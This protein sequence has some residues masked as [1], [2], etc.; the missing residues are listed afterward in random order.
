MGNPQC[1]NE[2]KGDAP[3]IPNSEFLSN[4]NYG[5]INNYGKGIIVKSGKE[6]EGSGCFTAAQSWLGDFWGRMKRWEVLA[7]FLLGQNSE[8]RKKIKP[9]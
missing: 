2:L 1:R 3:S 6:N 8:I 4:W 9:Y 7:G 5:I